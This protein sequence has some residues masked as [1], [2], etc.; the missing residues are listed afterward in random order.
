MRGK[1]RLLVSLVALPV[2]LPPAATA[3]GPPPLG[4]E[5]QVN[6][7]TTDFQYLAAAAMD[8]E[9]SFVVVWNSYLQDGVYGGI[10]GQRYEASGTPLG[11][12]FQVNTYTESAQYTPAV[13]ADAAGNF[14]VVWDSYSPDGNDLDV[15]AQRYD[16]DGNPVGAEFVVNTTVGGS[17]RDPAVAA[18][19]GGDFVVVWESFAGIFGQRYDAAGTPLGT[20][21]QVNTYTSDAAQFRPAVTADAAGN[22]VAVWESEGQDGSSRGVFGQRYDADGNPAGGEF[23]VN[24]YTKDAQRRPAV[25]A[26]ASGDFVV[27]WESGLQDGSYTGIFGQRFDGAGNALGPEFQVNSFTQYPQIRPDVVATDAGG[28]V[29]VWQSPG[30]DAS[31]GGVVGQRYDAAGVAV[32]G[33]FL[34]NTYTFATQGDPAVA[35]G[36]PGQF[37]VAWV[38]ASQDGSADGIFGQRFLGPVIF[39]D[40]FESS[41]TSAWDVTVP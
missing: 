37:V 8:G 34:V 20:E 17:Q 33:E 41:D 7:Y 19:A 2:V 1:G 21:F 23:Q 22:F 27:V 15:V 6:T 24:T 18:S 14:V 9:G 30:L 28:I 39:V 10:F 38:S 16:A 3:Q 4:E 11:S 5:F 31:D 40:G 35:A 13:A 12:E 36:P 25:A 29:V 26:A 32:G